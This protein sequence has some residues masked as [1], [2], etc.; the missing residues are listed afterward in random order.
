M[1]ILVLSDTHIPRVAA[2]LPEKIYEAIA[3]VDMILHAGD[4]VEKELLDKLA[5]LKGIK[6]VYGNMDG[7]N[8]KGRLND[9]EVVE[10]EGF[11]IGLIHGYGAPRD[12][13]DTVGREF[14]DVDAIVFGHSH[15][16]MNEVRGG[17]LLFNPGSPTDKIFA[18]TNSY[19]ILEVSDKGI[20]GRI[21]GL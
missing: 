7:P 4:F 14:A 13:P 2:D 6:A 9:K 1:K 5:V 11:R 8:L 18:K 12:L 21:I 17:I 19:G 10:V 15:S 3:G 20:L 16:P